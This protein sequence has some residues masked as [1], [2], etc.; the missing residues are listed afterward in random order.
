MD[1]NIG[2]II[3]AVAALWAA[4]RAG[5]LSVILP[6]AR[7]V[8]EEIE[9]G[10]LPANFLDDL[11][12][13]TSEEVLRLERVDAQYFAYADSSGKFL[14]QGQDFLSVFQSIKDR[15]PG[16]RFRVNRTQTGFSEEEVGSMVQSIFKVF[17]DKD[18]DNKSRQ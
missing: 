10:T 2:D 13:E 12:E 18:A 4:Y 6:L 14:A 1:F 11:S 17:G 3:L 15:F 8:K 9:D 16:Q 7:I 5:Q